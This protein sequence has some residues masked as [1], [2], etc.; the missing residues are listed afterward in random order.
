MKILFYKLGKSILITLVKW[1]IDLFEE[2]D[3]L[4]DFQ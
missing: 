1:N 2:E 3:I 4:R